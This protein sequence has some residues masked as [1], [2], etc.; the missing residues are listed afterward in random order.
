LTCGDI[1]V[2]FYGVNTYQW[3]GQQTFESSGYNTLTSDYT[4]Y[5]QPIFFSEFGCNLV[6][7]RT[8]QE[9]SAIY[10]TKMTGVFNGALAYEFTQEA[11]D[12]GLVEINGTTAQMLN[13][14]VAL[15]S[16]YT[17]VTSVTA[18]S[19]Q[20]VSRATTCPPANSY[21]HL[22][23]TNDLPDTPAADLI[24]NGIASNLYSPGKLITPSKWSTSYTILDNTGK[25]IT[26]KD[27]NN[28]G[29]TPSNPANGGAG[30][31]GNQVGG[32]GSNSSNST[33]KSNADALRFSPMLAGVAIGVVAWNNLAF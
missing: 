21:A 4:N 17:Q 30:T 20:S 11:N 6:K 33:A 27:I 28:S 1:Y 29:Y 19:V 7:P 18:G 8:F 14:Y 9:V 2:D 12:Y 32:S 22:N 3:C 13:D 31:S 23:G 24:K 26:D 5:S 10:S 15:Q 25:A 16:Q